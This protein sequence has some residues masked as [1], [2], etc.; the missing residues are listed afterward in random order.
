MGK[1]EK[2]RYGKERSLPHP[3]NPLPKGI[4]QVKNSWGHSPKIEDFYQQFMGSFLTSSVET[5]F[6]RNDLRGVHAVIDEQIPQNR[7]NLA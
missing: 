6:H 1:S 7:G 4:H 2:E 5:A 3:P